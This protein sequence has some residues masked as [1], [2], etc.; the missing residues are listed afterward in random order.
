MLNLI[1]HH[2]MRSKPNYSNPAG[3]LIVFTIIALTANA[4]IGKHEQYIAAGVDDYIAKPIDPDE[5]LKEISIWN[6]EG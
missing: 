4:M 1:L 6:F 2:I 3:W 5:L